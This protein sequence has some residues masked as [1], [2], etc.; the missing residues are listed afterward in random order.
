[1]TIHRRIYW[2][3]NS[4]QRIESRWAEEDLGLHEQ[5]Q[6]ASGFTRYYLLFAVSFAFSV[7]SNQQE[8]VPKPSATVKALENSNAI[9]AIAAN[10]CNSALENAVAEANE[11]SKLFNPL[12]WFK[13]IDAIRKVQASARMYVNMLG[14]MPGGAD[15]KKLLT[16]PAEQFTSRW[17]AD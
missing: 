9:I 15:L 7:A 14:S 4:G 13:T 1:V 2:L 12:N 17:S 10:C 3:L 16:L 11:K 8:K 5:L 6:A